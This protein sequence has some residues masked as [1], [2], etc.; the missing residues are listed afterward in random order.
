[1]SDVATAE[2]KIAVNKV[3]LLEIE[4]VSV[5][6][7]QIIHLPISSLNQVGAEATAIVDT[8]EIF[9]KAEPETTPLVHISG[10]EEGT[11]LEK[12]E[13]AKPDKVCFL[14]LI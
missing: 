12:E 6:L 7:W 8:K 11:G 14:C 3:V 2:V 9:K 13:L 4:S 1:V 5:I 10:V